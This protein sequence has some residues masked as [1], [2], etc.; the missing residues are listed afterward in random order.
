MTIAATVCVC[1]G[2]GQ[3]FV[4]CGY[5][6]VIVCVILQSA[7][8]VLHATATHDVISTRAPQPGPEGSKQASKEGKHVS[9]EALGFT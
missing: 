6:W 2:L 9:L 4:I 8:N 1:V 5:R 3:V 7:G